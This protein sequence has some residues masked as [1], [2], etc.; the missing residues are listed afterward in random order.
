MA[1]P[2]VVEPV[3]DE[4]GG[5]EDDEDDLDDD[6]EGEVVD[7]FRVAEGVVVRGDD[8]RL[9]PDDGSVVDLF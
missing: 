2:A 1:G 7:L 9:L 8:V 6:D 4:L 3:V 5:H